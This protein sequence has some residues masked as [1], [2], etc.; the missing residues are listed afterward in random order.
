MLCVVIM[1]SWQDI[2]VSL[3]FFFGKMLEFVQCIDLYDL[4]CFQHQ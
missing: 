1:L 3:S 4:I 2:L